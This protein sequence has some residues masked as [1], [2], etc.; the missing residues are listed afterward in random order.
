MCMEL[1]DLPGQDRAWRNG[2]FLVYVTGDGCRGFDDVRWGHGSQA[3]G[4]KTVASQ[5]VISQIQPYA[6]SD[7]LLG[8]IHGEEGG[9]V[10]LR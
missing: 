1:L 7:W 8:N 10:V 9:A 5:P 3:D 6:R 2:E 4:L